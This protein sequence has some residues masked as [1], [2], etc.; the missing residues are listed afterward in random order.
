[1][2]MPSSVSLLFTISAVRLS[3]SL[4]WAFTS[5]QFMPVKSG[6]STSSLLLNRGLVE[7]AKI[8]K[9][10]MAEPKA[11]AVAMPASTGSRPMRFFFFFRL[12]VPV[13]RL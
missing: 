13:V 3:L 5:S 2:M 8:I 12:W 4:Y 10:R 1:M 7:F 9:H 11:K 6:S